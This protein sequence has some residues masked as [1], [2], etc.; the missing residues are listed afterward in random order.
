MSAKAREAFDLAM[1]AI[2]A[3]APCVEKKLSDAGSNPTEAFVYST[4]KYF[5][6]LNRLAE[7]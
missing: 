1:K 6:A 3:N 4:A 2:E 5:D 7:E